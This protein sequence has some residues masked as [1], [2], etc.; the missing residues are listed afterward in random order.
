WKLGEGTPEDIRTS[1]VEKGRSISIGSIRN[2]LG[3]MMQKGYL[4]R[5]KNGKAYYYRASIIRDEARKNMIRDLLVNAFEGSE[6]LIVAALLNT[7]EIREEE[8]EEIRRLV[9]DTDKGEAS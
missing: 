2:M 3:I 9:S 6:S 1:L 4:S 7:G 8:L 5:K